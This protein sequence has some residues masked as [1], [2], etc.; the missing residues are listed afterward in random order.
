MTMKLKTTILVNR[1]SGPTTFIQLATPSKSPPP[2]VEGVVQ[3]NQAKGTPQPPRNKTLAIRLNTPTAANSAMKKIRK[4]KPEYSVMNPE[5]SS[6]SAI[7]MSNGVWVSSAW[8]AIM[9][10]T[11]P[12][13]WV[14]T[15]GLPRPSQPN[16]SPEFW[17]TT[18]P[19]MFI[20]PAWITTPSTA[21][22]MGSS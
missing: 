8:T 7:G 14:R 4:R 2:V 10:I 11:N 22:T 19:C 6:D 3:P 16:I 12:M 17:A 9:K 13:N 20:V 1:M 5:T 18:M 21:K 15:Y